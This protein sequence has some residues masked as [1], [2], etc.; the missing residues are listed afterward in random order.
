MVCGWG[1]PRH[2][3]WQGQPDSGGGDQSQQVAIEEPAVEQ[4][5]A[6]VVLVVVAEAAV[7]DALAGATDTSQALQSDLYGSGQK[8]I[9]LHTIGKPKR[10]WLPANLTDTTVLQSLFG[11]INSA[12]N[13]RN[14]QVS[15]AIQLGSGI[16]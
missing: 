3:G 4:V 11:K 12:S 13:P 16:C 15:I 6:A 10:V 9:Q 8:H 1:E 14:I 5:Q 2:G 7:A